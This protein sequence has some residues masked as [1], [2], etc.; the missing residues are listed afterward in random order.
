MP[1]K[2]ERLSNAEKISIVKPY[3]VEQI[4]IYDRSDEATIDGVGWG[5]RTVDDSDAFSGLA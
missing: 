5:V 1:Q 4:P 2:R 3:L